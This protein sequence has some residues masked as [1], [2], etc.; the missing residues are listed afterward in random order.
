MELDRTRDRR[1]G[2]QPPVRPEWVATANALGGGLDLGGVIPLDPG[3]LIEAARRGTGLDDFGADDWRAPFEAL[4]SALDGEASLNFMGRVMAR[5][6]L[7]TFLEGRLRVEEAYRICP[8][9][10]DEEIRA[11]LWIIG[12]GRTGTSILQKLLALDPENRTLK[13]YEALFPV[14][15][16]LGEGGIDP[17]I[18]R[19]DDRMALWRAVTPQI[20]SVHDFGG[21]EPMETIMAESMSF[22][23][24]AW[25]N[26]L[27]LTPSYNASLGAKAR[28]HSLA[29]LRR[30]L[31]LLQWQ[32]PGGR[33][34]L[35]SPD[36]MGYLPE[37]V[38][39]FPDV[40]LV[41][42]HRDPIVALSSA[43]NMIGT[44]IWS[45]SDSVPPAGLF[46]FITDP[47]TSAAALSQPIAWLEEGS[48]PAAQV[49]HAHYAALVG[50]PVAAIEAIY[51][52]FGITLGEAGRSALDSYVAASRGRARPTHR[53][54][55]GEPDQIAAERRCFARY[56]QYFGV[57]SEA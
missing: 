38:R 50:G 52:A 2:W 53:Y 40:R 44:L 16:A 1:A 19:A 25:L 4:V 21:D 18:A 45:R 23:T 31:K 35:K 26:L 47:Q 33:W 28:E 7:L 43:V 37:V 14:A 49:C 54:T 27:G 13:T 6:D 8:E 56:Q 24:P 3:S 57:P 42:T 10:D 11:P 29:Y 30:V 36:A 5:S 22:Q 48:V 32:S 20:D 51:G 39:A 34:V 41:W 17:R 55:I 12:Q 15:E 46:D 9:I